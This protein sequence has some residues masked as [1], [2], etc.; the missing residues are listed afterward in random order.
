MLATRWRSQMAKTT[1]KRP[2]DLTVWG[3]FAFRHSTRFR[4]AKDWRPRMK[5]VRT[6]VFSLGILATALSAVVPRLQAG[7]LD[8]CQR[9]VA[10]AEHELH[11]AMEKHGRHSR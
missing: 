10:H 8:E 2:R 3:V 11:V 9:R 7:D 4:L 5:I 6:S 1:P